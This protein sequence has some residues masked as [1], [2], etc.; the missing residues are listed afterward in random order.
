MLRRTISTCLGA[1]SLVLA[2]HACAGISL[3]STRLVFNSPN[4]EA[5][6]TVR[7]TGKDVLVQSWID[8]DKDLDTPPPFA[9]TPPLARVPA[10]ERQLLRILY[11]GSGMPTDRESVVWLNVQ[12]IPQ[13]SEGR[14]IL[15]LAVRQRIKMFFRPEGLKTEAH[16]APEELQWQLARLG[17]KTELKL[18]NPGKY[19]VSMS[20]V[21][22][23]TTVAVDS[24]M[25]APGEER[26]FSVPDLPSAKAVDLT[27]F[28]IN[29]YG[30]LVPYSASLSIGSPAG[31]TAKRSE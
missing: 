5:S 13:T 26:V 6:I 31:A 21:K 15:Q 10:N 19:H 28:S 12:E 3:S 1:L 23:G 16:R 30:A 22:L 17:G 11:E 25:I 4:K 2:S 8:S 9:V 29:D 27:F 14:N 7:N 18:R 24:T 20:D